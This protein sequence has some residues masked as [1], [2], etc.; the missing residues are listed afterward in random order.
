MPPPPRIAGCGTLLS[1]LP[2]PVF[3]FSGH[4]ICFRHLLIL[5]PSLLETEPPSQVQAGTF[6]WQRD[7]TALP[8]Q[9]LPVLR[10]R[11]GVRGYAWGWGAMATPNRVPFRQIG[12][13]SP[14]LLPEMSSQV[15]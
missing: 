15:T 2:V 1:A 13:N 14:A 6:S 3:Q 8:S 11:E 9:V 5:P 10:G 4:S 7:P 12:L